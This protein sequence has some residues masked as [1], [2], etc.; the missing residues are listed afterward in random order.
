MAETALITGASS[1]IGYE[2]AKLFAQDHSSLVLVA[3]NKSALDQLA[4]ELS[5][6]QGITVT[7]IVKDLAQH[8]SCEEILW[9][10]REKRIHIDVLVNNAG[11]G[12]HRP[13][14]ETDLSGIQEMMQVNMVALTHL[15]REL[16]PPMIEKRKGIICN[17]AS[18]AAFQPGPLMAV[19]YATKAYVL[20]LSEAIANELEGTGVSVTAICPGPTTTEF[21]KRAGMQRSK[22]LDRV[23]DA[24]SVAEIG[25]KGM[26]KGKTIVI[27]GMRNKLLAQSVRL[28]PRKVVTQIVRK[29]QENR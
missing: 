11:L 14:L 10:L 15:T 29:L 21:Q 4:A 9:E 1:G 22:L 28:G 20:W 7:V 5:A 2:L 25:Y 6:K 19:Y 18:T 24:A 3:R 23:M 16:L 8:S 13:F 12:F 17:V 26:R 27:T